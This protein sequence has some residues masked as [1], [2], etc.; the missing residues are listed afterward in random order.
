MIRFPKRY[1]DT[2][3]KL[4]VPAGFLLL[5]AFL[6][7]ATPTLRSFFWGVP[8][9]GVGLWLRGWAA[10]HL[11]KNR[12][13]AQSGPYAWTR[14]PLY[15]GTLVTVLGLAVAAKRPLLAWIFWAVFS[16]VYL[17]VIQL[18]EEHLR[19][20]FPKFG[21]YERRVPLL[22]PKLPENAPERAFEWRLYQ[23]NEEYKA[24]IAFSIAALYLFWRAT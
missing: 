1:A 18:E 9:A 6:Y 3:A 2:V 21:E 22:F 14:N 11:D 8:I 17:P 19:K 16:F 13:L 20:L 23:Q 15:L 4:R 5:A 12:D 24:L 7:L 10:G